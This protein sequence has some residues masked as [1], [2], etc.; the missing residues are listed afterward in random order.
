MIVCSADGNPK[1]TYS[2][3]SVDSGFVID[4]PNL[5]VTYNMTWNNG[6][7]YIC[8]ASTEISERNVTWTI[9]SDVLFIHM[10]NQGDYCT[11]S[12]NF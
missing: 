7:K 5:V 4:G 2:W 8:S 1:P 10:S 6:F 3:K 11:A 12:E 9:D